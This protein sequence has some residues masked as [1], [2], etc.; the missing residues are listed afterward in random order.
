[1]PKRLPSVLLRQHEVVRRQAERIVEAS[2]PR[3]RVHLFREYARAVGG[4]IRVIDQVVVPTL[5]MHR[6]RGVSS[7]LLVGHVRMKQH[8]AEALV[9][10][11]QGHD[12]DGM[13]QGLLAEVAQQCAK[14]SAELVPL[15]KELL[16]DDESRSL[17]GQAGAQFSLV[18]D[19]AEES[20]SGYACDLID[21]ARVVLSTLPA[22]AGSQEAQGA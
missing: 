13:V 12:I 8:I 11:Q 20:R 2:N 5:Q 7:D 3:Y 17:G 21:E 10:V 15:L 1:M 14:E 19:S 6:W 18:F 16:G 4:H 9:A 22:T